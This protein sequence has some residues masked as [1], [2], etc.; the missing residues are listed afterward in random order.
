MAEGRIASRRRRRRAFTV[1]MLAVFDRLLFPAIEDDDESKSSNTDGTA[2][3]LADGLTLR[4]DVLIGG[5]VRS[6]LATA[7]SARVR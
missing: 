5:K 7:T 1:C 6:S 4:H 3:P 2:T